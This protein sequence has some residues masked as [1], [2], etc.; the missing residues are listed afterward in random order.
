MGTLIIVILCILV[1]VV[2]AVIHPEF[3]WNIAAAGFCAGL[4]VSM[5]MDYRDQ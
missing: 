3:W 2:F 1:N 4:L 5:L